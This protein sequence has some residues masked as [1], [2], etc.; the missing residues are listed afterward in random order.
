MTFPPVKQPTCEDCEGE[1]I[2]WYC[3]YCDEEYSLPEFC[4]R[5]PVC[6]NTTLD[7]V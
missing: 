4:P 5:C 2:L 1:L 6:G 7:E 3:S